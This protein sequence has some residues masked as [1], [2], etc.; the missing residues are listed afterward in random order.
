M[1]LDK[2]ALE[3]KLKHAQNQIDVE[4]KKR[5]RAETDFQHLEQQ[6][7]L[8][9]DVL[10]HDGQ[11]YTYRCWLISTAEEGLVWYVLLVEESQP[12]HVFV[13]KMTEIYRVPGC[14]R[15]VRELKEK[16][17]RGKGFPPLGKVDDIHVVWGLLNDFLRKLKEPLVTFHLHKKFMDAGDILD[18]DDGTLAIYKAIQELPQPNKDTLAFLIL[19]LQWFSNKTK[20]VQARNVFHISNPAVDIKGAGQAVV[21]HEASL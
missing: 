13:S 20:S 1:D 3:V 16:C 18:D 15:T 6:M 8:I 4:M 11:S 5:H 17:M 21:D 12:Q 9:C 10:M 2:S 19:H 7:Q 14:D